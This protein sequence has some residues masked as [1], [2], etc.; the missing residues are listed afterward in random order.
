MMKAIIILPENNWL[1][2]VLSRASEELVTLDWKTQVTS[3]AS[4]SREPES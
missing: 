1:K 3:S 2:R 4:K